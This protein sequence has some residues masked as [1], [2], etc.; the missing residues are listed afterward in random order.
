M[1]CS[2]SGILAYCYSEI[3]NEYLMLTLLIALGLNLKLFNKNI[4]IIE[5]Y[6]E[7]IKYV[8]PSPAREGC[9]H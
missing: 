9:L 2:F 6:F 8:V 7:I 3:L 5:I 1:S 4:Q